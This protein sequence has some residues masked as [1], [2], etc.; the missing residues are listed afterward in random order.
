MKKFT[1]LYDRIHNCHICQE[2][3]M[4]K[5]L[6]RHSLKMLMQVETGLLIIKSIK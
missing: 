6:R 3:D 4:E 5:A 2:M 1:D